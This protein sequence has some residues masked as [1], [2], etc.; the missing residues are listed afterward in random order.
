MACEIGYQAFRIERVKH[1]VP[2]RL[3]GP[4][5]HQYRQLSRALSYNLENQPDETKGVRYNNAFLWSL[6]EAHGSMPEVAER[7]EAGVEGARE[8]QDEFVLALRIRSD[9]A[10]EKDGSMWLHPRREM[11][12]R[13]SDAVIAMGQITAALV[14]EIY[15]G[16][17]PSKVDA[18]FSRLRDGQITT[19]GR[20]GKTKSDVDR[21]LRLGKDPNHAPRYD[22]PRFYE[23]WVEGLRATN[24]PKVFFRIG[25]LG[26]FAGARAFQALAL[27]MH[28]L[29]VRPKQPGRIS[30]P[31]KG[32]KRER[33]IQFEPV[34][35]EYEAILDY[36]DVER[37]KLT[38][39]SLDALRLMAANPRQKNELKSMPLF[40]EDGV[41]FIEYDR[42]YRVF[43]R[44]AVR[45]GLY[46]CDEEFRS[47]DRRRYVSFHYLRHEYVHHRLDLVDA[48]PVAER[49]AARKAIIRY[50]RWSDGDAMLDWY[51]AHH[52]VKV[53]SQAAAL[54]NSKISAE[55][56][57]SSQAPIG[58]GR[59]D[60]AEVD[61][62]LA[63][64]A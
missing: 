37:R 34:A 12:S 31:N 15:G 29:L 38:G 10:R 6:N 22:D 42:L 63:E 59:M 51:S 27:T 54:H 64:L 49:P 61:E 2:L 14:D 45:A 17:D 4:D 11:W 30:S 57:A 18:R 28:D 40:T 13:V 23:R 56:A 52:M 25:G 1:P 39:M 8:A 55:L 5:G 43:R 7:Y 16:Q 35:E 50:F 47:M 58:L 9:E 53:G 21:R 32:S 20:D 46:I 62:M 19:R 48:L 36:V 41:N 26:R 24:A 3:I 60:N 44:A 33:T